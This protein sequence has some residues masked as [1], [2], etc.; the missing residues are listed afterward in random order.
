MSAVTN[1]ISVPARRLEGRIALVVGGGADGPPRPGETLAMG[2]G[3]AIALRLAA[4]GATVAVT[5]ID[6]DS[7][8]A[9][10]AAAGGGLAIQADLADPEACR[11]AVARTERELGPIDI[12]VLNAAI[13]GR[14]PLRAQTLEDWE[15]SAHVNV[16][17]HWVTA[18]AALEP[19]LARG[20]GAFVFVG[21]TGGTLSSGASL[22][23]EATKAAQMAVMR[24]IAVRY[25]AR[26]IRSNGVVLG[27]I[28]STMV[29]RTYG[30]GADRHAARSS[31]VPMRREGAPE[32]AAAAAAFL[33]SDDASYVNGHALVVDGG[34]SAAWPSPPAVPGG[35]Q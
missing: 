25:G 32:E 1:P 23:Y 33:A 21:S 2:N 8:A 26:G 14:Q 24:H 18:Q 3:R 13:S 6:A 34:V 22:A 15:R 9:T 12:V 31:V 30:D 19:M 35:K 10:V 7:A 28:D 16:R 29:R 17:G 20:R 5:D 11:E 4:E 27:I